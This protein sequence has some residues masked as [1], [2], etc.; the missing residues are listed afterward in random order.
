MALAGVYNKATA[1]SGPTTI[2]EFDANSDNGVDRKI[3]EVPFSRG[4][5]TPT[6]GDIK[7]YWNNSYREIAGCNYFLEN[8]T[9]I[10]NMDATKR[11]QMIAEVSFLRDFTYYNMSQYW[12]GVPLVTKILTMDEA[13]SAVSAD[14]VTI[15][16]FVLEELNE[17]I[18]D[19]PATRPSAEHGRI[20]KGAALAIKGRLLMSENNW[21][22]AVEAYREI[23]E[24]GVHN[25]DPA[26]L[27][28]FNGKKEQSSEIIFTRKYLANEI[29][30]AI[31]L[32]YRPNVDGG[33]HHM[34]P[35]QS[36]LDAYLCLDG[37]TI[38]DSELYDPNNPVLKNGTSYRDPRLLYTIYYPGISV[39]KGKIYHGHPDSTTVVGDVFTY[40][41]GMTGYCL[42]KYVDEGYTGDVYSGGSDIPIVRYAEVLL[43]YL[44]CKIKNN[45]SIN[46]ELL[47]QTIN[48]IRKREAV[49][50]PEVTETNPSALWEI[51]KRER[52]IE[53]A[54]EGLRYWDLIRWGE[55]EEVLNGPYYGIKITDDPENYT[56][57][58]VGPTGHYYVTD[59]IFRSSD[60]PWPFPQDE[61][62]INSNLEQKDNWD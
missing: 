36:L 49:N 6:L 35:F 50:M 8:I 5:I 57:F 32:H 51:L 23:I 21:S 17:S 2:I 13:N 47:D 19:L 10:G 14:K 24:L 58:R 34:N 56:R 29:G 40:D 30:N 44:E 45:E 59:L 52:R 22:A 33:W 62:D 9:S 39:I 31:Q 4:L 38:E 16:N 53:L 3:N 20:T 12:G 41:A 25:I 7:S 54:W 55:A 1:W 26:Y 15:V 42:R 37:K 60:L 48:K 46:Q 43:S 61:L 18:P 11:N 28:L 27:E